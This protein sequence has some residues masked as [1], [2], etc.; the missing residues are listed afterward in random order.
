MT[1]ETAKVIDGAVREKQHLWALAMRDAVDHGN[2]ATIAERE[3]PSTNEVHSPARSNSAFPARC[4]E[5]IHA[6]LDNLIKRV[7]SG[8]MNLR[9]AKEI[10][11]KARAVRRELAGLAKAKASRL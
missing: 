4:N 6:S 9:S 2:I 7:E 1:P 11:A 3:P 8:E 5:V 10:L